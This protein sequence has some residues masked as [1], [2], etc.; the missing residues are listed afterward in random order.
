[1]SSNEDVGNDVGNNDVV[2]GSGEGNSQQ[3]QQQGVTT[4]SSIII[5]AGGG[6]G[7]KGGGSDL[8]GATYHYGH[9]P[10]SPN[11][12]SSASSWHTDMDQHVVGK[13]WRPNSLSPARSNH[14]IL[15]K[16]RERM[17]SY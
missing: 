5:R 15:E 4:I 10:Q 17:I 11:Q 14:I 12:Q 8:G 2:V 3:Q 9:Q 13:W 6:G 1:M 7:D 16:E